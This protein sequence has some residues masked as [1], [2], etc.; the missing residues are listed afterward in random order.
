MS[1][2]QALIDYLK[3]TRCNNRQDDSF[4]T[5]FCTSSR[6]R[7]VSRTTLEE[8]CVGCDAVRDDYLARA[9]TALAGS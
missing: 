7:N 5:N 1:E 2:Q 4:D 8:V 3:I 9:F 6:A